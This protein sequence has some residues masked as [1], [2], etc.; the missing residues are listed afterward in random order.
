MNPMKYYAALISALFIYTILSLFWGSNSFH[1]MRE[2]KDAQN[3]LKRNLSELIRIN[4]SLNEELLSLSHDPRPI[5]IKSR[6]LMF[7]EEGDK[8]LC[9]NTKHGM[10]LAGKNYAGKILRPHISVP[11]NRQAFQIISLLVFAGASL[12]IFF[13]GRSRN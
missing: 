7:L 13:R 5:A 8:L 11:Q 2:L 10:D 6:N 3:E 9:I 1:T 12:L 4:E